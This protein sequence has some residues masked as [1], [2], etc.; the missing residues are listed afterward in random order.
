MTQN[1]PCTEP[2]TTNGGGNVGDSNGDTNGDDNGDAN[3]LTGG[4][5][6]TEEGMGLGTMALIGLGI[7]GLGFFAF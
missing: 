6:E 1:Q 3:G 7:V 2:S 4:T 5:T